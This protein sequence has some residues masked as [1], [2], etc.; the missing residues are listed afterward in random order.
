MHQGSAFNSGDD[1]AGI[2]VSAGQTASLHFKPGDRVG[3][4]HPLGKPS[5]AFAEYAIGQAHTTF[6]VPEHIS[7]EEAATFPM[8]YSTAAML[9]QRQPDLASPWKKQHKRKTPFLVWSAGSAVGCFVLK[10]AKLANISPVIAVANHPE[11]VATLLD[12]LTDAVFT[13][14]QAVQGEINKFLNGRKLEHA[15]DT[16]CEDGSTVEVARVMHASQPS[17]KPEICTLLGLEGEALPV[18]AD[19]RTVWVSSIHYGYAHESFSPVAD[20]DYTGDIE[21]GSMIF[22][23]LSHWLVHKKIDGHPYEVIEGGLKGVQVGLQRLK[24]G[25]HRGKKMVFS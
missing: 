15:Y 23:L 17:K 10:L 21:Y 20:Q 4:Y 7:F 5:G 8:A 14:E 16:Y 12:D 11:Y 22:T 1:L 2:V 25:K 13:Y 24:D 3:T 9:F 6:H 19:V 18:D